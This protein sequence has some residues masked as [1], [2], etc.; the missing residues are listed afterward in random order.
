MASEAQTNR[1]SLSEVLGG[2]HLLWHMW[3]R[4]ASVTP[5]DDDVLEM[6]AMYSGDPD[7]RLLKRMKTNE[8]VGCDEEMLDEEPMSTN[9]TNSPVMSPASDDGIFSYPRRQNTDRS[10]ASRPAS[11]SS[12]D[13]STSRPKPKRGQ[14]FLKR[15][16]SG[17]SLPTRRSVDMETQDFTISQPREMEVKRR[18]KLEDYEITPDEDEMLLW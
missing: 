14:S 11:S 16:S 18:K 9:S 8:E 13:W 10:P 3:K 1:S 6:H 12:T 4:R 2:D 15:L 17:I 5:K 7:M